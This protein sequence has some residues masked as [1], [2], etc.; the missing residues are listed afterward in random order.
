MGVPWPSQPLMVSPGCDVVVGSGCS[1][2][3]LHHPRL[4]Y[5]DVAFAKT[6]SSPFTTYPS[7]QSSRNSTSCE[8]LADMVVQL[9]PCDRV[10]K[11]LTKFIRSTHTPFYYLHLT[12]TTSATTNIL[13]PAHYT[14]LFCPTR[15][16][17]T[18]SSCHP[19]LSV[20][21]VVTATDNLQTSYVDNVATRIVLQPRQ[22]LVIHHQLCRLFSVLAAAMA[23][24]L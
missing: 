6:F 8:P 1:L 17:F 7:R 16:T 11:Q 21:T 3:C 20:P 2:S 22:P 19:S 9:P 13:H 10:W 5:S 12:Q 23:T 18:D 14:C 15:Y 24:G 4:Y